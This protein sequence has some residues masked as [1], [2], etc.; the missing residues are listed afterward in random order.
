MP[1]VL[2]GRSGGLRVSKW[3]LPLP[4]K[5]ANW[6]GRLTFMSPLPGFGVRLGGTE[7]MEVPIQAGSGDERPGA[8]I[9]LGEVAS[10]DK[11]IDRGSTYSAQDGLC[12]GNFE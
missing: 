2:V 7:L 11:S 4:W 9:H 12:V 5:N 10:I 1:R 3:G 8:K 6:G